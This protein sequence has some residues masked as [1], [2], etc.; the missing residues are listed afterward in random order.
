MA[1]EVARLYRESPLAERQ[2]LAMAGHPDGVIAFGR[3][4]DEA[5]QVL[6][7]YLARAHRP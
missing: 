7:T 2:I 5:G 1:R 4:V 3:S 6:M